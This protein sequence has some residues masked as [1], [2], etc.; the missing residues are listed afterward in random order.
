MKA[1]PGAS[2]PGGSSPGSLIEGGGWEGQSLAGRRKGTDR[3]DGAP[4]GGR[5]R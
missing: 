3:R 4:G 2:A 1:P 5:R